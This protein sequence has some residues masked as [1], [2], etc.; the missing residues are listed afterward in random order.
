MLLKIRSVSLMPRR[1]VQALYVP[2]DKASKMCAVLVPVLDFDKRLANRTKIEENIR[3]RKCPPS[4]DVDNLYAQWDLYKTIQERK[5]A[6]EARRSEIGKLANAAKKMIASP[7][8]ANA[9]RLY[10][11]EG[12]A[13]RDDWKNIRDHSYS[14]ESQFIND[15]LDLPNEL[16]PNTP[17]TTTTIASFND[18]AKGDDKPKPIHL[19][20][21]D[22]IEFVDESAFYLKNDAAQFDMHFP[23]HCV[24]VFRDRDFV[25]F[26]NPDF[27]R[28]IAVEAGAVP[29]DEVYE[30]KRRIE[31]EDT[32]HLHLVGAGSI[33]SFLGF[34]AKLLVPPTQFPF[35]WIATGKQYYPPKSNANGGLF[36]VCQSTCVQTFLAGTRD[37][38]EHEF[39]ET[40]KLM[41]ELYESF[42]MHFRMVQ[43]G[44]DELKL[45]ESQGVR[46]EMFSSHLQRYVEVGRL[47]H[48]SNFISKRILFNYPENK[49][50]QFPDVIAG[51]VCNATRMLAI[52]LENNDGRVVKTFRKT[53]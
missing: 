33:L 17:D 8:K 13:L 12:I 27:A 51:T 47:S 45:A 39:G 6:I 40:L 50:S 1:F 15:F 19:E 42:D 22:Q 30:V 48:F 46:F 5:K 16:H 36:N 4:I 41:Q 10:E 35:R 11:L 25:E 9:F 38:M 43:I 20:Y 31:I 53:F 29:L 49:K 3:R 44:A 24:D 18:N 21:S 52:L 37:Q 14:L 34:V 23:Y 26:S 7:D 32:N 2:G 28:T